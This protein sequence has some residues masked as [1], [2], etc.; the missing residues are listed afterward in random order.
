M[1]YKDYSGQFIDY[2]DP[3]PS[4]CDNCGKL[5]PAEELEDHSFRRG[6]T[7][8]IVERHVCKECDEEIYDEAMSQIGDY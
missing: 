2:D 4:D 5:V 3:E 8:I 1:S 7:E 6:D